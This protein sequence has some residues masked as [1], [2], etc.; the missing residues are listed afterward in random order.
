MANA[1]GDALDIPIWG[2]HYRVTFPILDG[3][4]DMVTGAAGLDSEVSKDA[5]AFAD[6]TNEATEIG[7]TGVYYLDITGAEMQAK[8]VAVQVKTST[9][10]AKTTFIII[11]P[12]R[13]PII[14]TG[15]AQGGA[16]GAITLDA[17]ASDKDGA[18]DG[19]FVRA[20]NNSPAG[21][22]YATRRII[23]YVGSTRVATVEG[24]WGTNPDN[25]TTYDILAEAWVAVAGRGL[26]RAIVYQ[27]AAAPNRTVDLREGVGLLIA[28]HG[29]T[30]GIPSS[31]Q[32]F[33]GPAVA[34]PGTPGWNITSADGVNRTTSTATP[35][36]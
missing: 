6:C 9:T 14:E 10:G 25:T 13:L 5:A 32:T 2:S 18:Y 33:A 24:N 22:Q 30:S 28:G 23:S 15:T 4:G 16:A 1:A 34:A 11:N 7:A 20:N 3:N 35:P 36:K 19:L 12:K 17:A 29:P 27:D 8:T 21:V 26:T 31:P